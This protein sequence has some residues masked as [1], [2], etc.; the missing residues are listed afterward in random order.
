MV[1]DQSHITRF[2][3]VVGVLLVWQSFGQ[4]ENAQFGAWTIPVWVGLAEALLLFLALGVAAMPRLPQVA[5]MLVLLLVGLILVNFAIEYE[6]HD[7]RRM[8]WAT[9]NHLYQEYAAYALELG[10]NPYTVDTFH[11]YRALRAQ[12]AF[13]TQQLDGDY[14][15][16]LI[17]P[18]LSFLILIPAHWLGAPSIY[19]YFVALVLI[20]LVLYFGS[21]P[22]LRPLMPL[23]L[24]IFTPYIQ[25]SF[26]GLGET[27]WVLFTMMMILRWKHPLEAAVWYGLACAYKQPPWMYA[28]FLALLLWRDHQRPTIILRFALVSLATFLVFNLP[29]ML[30]N[31][32]AWFNDVF[33]DIFLGAESG[34]GDW[35][36]V[37]HGIGRDRHSRLGI[38]AVGAG[39]LCSDWV[40]VLPPHG[41]L[42][43]Y[44]PAGPWDLWLLL[45]IGL[46]TTIGFSRFCHFCLRCWPIRLRRRRRQRSPAESIRP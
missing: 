10:Q 1:I 30:W 43:L 15:G 28:P 29:F 36:V 27:V 17:Y 44:F 34:S 11:A 23:A 19:V 41:S 46:S 37:V 38:H 2:S 12:Q 32:S 13:P 20:G 8:P 4:L 40:P 25:L 18:S 45:R 35:A 26:M 31:P 3:I 5:G 9:D 42:T 7:S 16:N 24:V 21:P 22:P 33:E 6:S 39:Q 14:V